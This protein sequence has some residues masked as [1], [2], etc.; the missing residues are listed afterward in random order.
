MDFQDGNRKERGSTSMQH[1]FK[2]SLLALLATARAFGQTPEP[3]PVAARPNIVADKYGEL[4]AGCHG[5]TLAG[6]QGPSLVDDTWLHGG[7]DADI[8]RVIHDGV[9][10]TS[11]VSFKAALNDQQIR[12]M[13]IYIREMGVKAR[14]GTLST[15]PPPLPDS[16]QTEKQAFRAELVADGLDMPWGMQFLPDGRILVTERPGNLRIIDKGVV[17]APIA[18]VPKVWVKQDAGLL[19][20]ALH[21]DY[22][23]NGWVYLGFVETGGSAPGASTTKVIR[24]RIVDGSLVDQQTLFQAPQELYWDDNTHFGLRFIFDRQG[25]LFYS[26]G[27]RGHPETSQD[28]GSPYGKLHRIFD[29]GRVPSDNPFVHT[30]GAVASIWSWGHRNQQGLAFQPGSGLLWSTEHGPRGGDE[31]NIVRKGR[32]YGWPVITYGMNY[33][34][35]P[36]TDLTRKKGMEQPVVYWTP[37]IATGAIAFSTSNRYPR[38]KNDLFLGALAGQQLRRLEIRGERVVHQEVLWRGYGRVRDVI[39][40]PDGLL[41]VMLNT[42]GKIVRLVPTN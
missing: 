8:A 29:D 41:Y 27:D 13:V 16:F 2:F 31:L 36:I 32:N 7:E 24:G 39:Q 11:M 30:P 33:D 25:H 28:L 1:A 20:V 6:G 40:G 42:P 35:T 3:T 21:P 5:P 4:C 26:I 15:T 10:K 23:K 14:N 37:S 9:A 22:A 17:G 38:W 12:A 18:G 19:D 34:G